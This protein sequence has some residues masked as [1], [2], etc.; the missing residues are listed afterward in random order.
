[1]AGTIDPGT[2]MVISPENMDRH[3]LPLLEELDYKRLDLEVPY[4]EEHLATGENIAKY[5]WDKLKPAL[6]NGL[7][8]LKISET[9]KSS[10]EYFEE[11]G[12]P[13]ER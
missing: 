6:G 12:Y 9:E 11:G 3:V 8:H 7:V 2:G 1:M 10:F 5:I 13:Y 4:F